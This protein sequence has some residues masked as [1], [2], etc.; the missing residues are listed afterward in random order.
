MN[1]EKESTSAAKSAATAKCYVEAARENS[2]IAPTQTAGKNKPR[3]AERHERK[4][5]HVR[6]S[7]VVSLLRRFFVRVRQAQNRAF[8]KVFAKNLHADRQ[9]LF[10]RANRD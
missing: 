10:R 2:T 1:A 7:F 6:S 8:R 5:P 3:R 9:L 4:L